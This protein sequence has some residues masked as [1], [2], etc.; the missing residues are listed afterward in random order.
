MGVPSR[1]WPSTGSHGDGRCQRERDA[2][3]KLREE[4]HR[5]FPLVPDLRKIRGI[6]LY[7]SQEKKHKLTLKEVMRYADHKAKVHGHIMRE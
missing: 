7:Q 2:T 1:A 4:S 6:Y 3:T 5:L